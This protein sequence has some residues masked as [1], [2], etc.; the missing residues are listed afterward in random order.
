M[1]N[2]SNR[3]AHRPERPPTVPLDTRQPIW[4][5]FFSVAPLVLVGTKEGDG[6]YD[7]APKHMAMPLGWQNYF[8][9]VCTPTHGTYQN[10]RRHGEFTVSYPQ[11]DQV[12]LSSLSASPRC[13]DQSKPSLAALTT[14]P[15]TKVDGM[16]VE[17][18]YLFLECRLERIIDGF[19]VNSLIIGNVL[20][21][22]ALETALR[23]AEQDENDQIYA[24]PLLAYLSPGRF[25]VIRESTAFPL[26]AGFTR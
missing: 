4:D 3:D 14:F 6:R 2:Q 10:I 22:A 20:A 15:A 8:C 23:S 9:F 18:C 12:L 13:D 16:L 19:G 11:P 21:A 24:A 25:A 26:P 17:G 1:T 5:R 7:L